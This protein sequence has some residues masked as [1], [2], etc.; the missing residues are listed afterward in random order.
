MLTVAKSYFLKYF[1]ERIIKQKMLLT[2]FF[3]FPMKIMSKLSYYNLLTIAL[4]LVWEEGMERNEKNNFRILFPS[5]VW[6]F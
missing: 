5:L 2:S 3:I 6:E 4:G 1:I